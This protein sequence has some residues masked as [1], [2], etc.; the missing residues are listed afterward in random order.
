LFVIFRLYPNRIVTG[1]IRFLDRDLVSLTENELRGIRGGSIGMIFQEPAKYLNPS[2]RIGEQIAE[3]LKTH[4]GMNNQ[5]ATDEAKRL[6]DTVE[7]KTGIADRYPHELSGGMKQRV[8]IAQA[9][10]CRPKLLLA[11][12]PTTAL[13][14]TV[15]KQILDLLVRLGS[16]LGL[17]ILIVTHDLGVVSEIAHTVSVMYAGRIVESGPI[18]QVL[19]S[20]RHPYTALLLQAVPNPENRGDALAAIPGA[21]PHPSRL[22]EGCAFH[23]RC[24]YKRERCYRELPSLNGTASGQAVACFFPVSSAEKRK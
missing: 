2:M 23:P 12:E 24:P 5:I 9:I 22:P 15:Q 3:I 19:K 4:R 13:D 18:P 14:V 6:L 7:L 16:T 1:G 11:D 17:S 20:P 21:I 8:M 10:S